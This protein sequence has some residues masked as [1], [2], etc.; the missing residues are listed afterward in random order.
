MMKAMI[1][2]NRH[3]LT[4]P[5]F[6]Q[7][8]IA[9]LFLTNMAAVFFLPRVEA[10]VVLVS[11]GIGAMMQIGLFDRYGFVR[12]LGAGHFHWILM[13]GWLVTRLPAIPSGSAYRSWVLAVIVVCSI[14]LVIDIVDVIR[15]ARGERAP[16]IVIQA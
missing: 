14:S 6:W 1:G 13:I 16:T 8:W 5:V 3:I 7:L 15:F 9:L 4:M 10:V 2:F 12:L 11:L